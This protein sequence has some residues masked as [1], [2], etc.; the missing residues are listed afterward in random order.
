MGQI[1]LIAQWKVY[2]H[3]ESILIRNLK[4]FSRLLFSVEIF[5]RTLRFPLGLLFDVIAMDGMKAAQFDVF[6]IGY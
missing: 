2:I 1:F 5:T 6:T 3:R 4:Y